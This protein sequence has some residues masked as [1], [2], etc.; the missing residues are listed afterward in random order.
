M[1]Q[2]W[3][4]AEEVLVMSQSW[5]E[6]GEV[7]VMPVLPWGFG[8]PSHSVGLGRFGDATVSLWNWVVLVVPQSRCGIFGDVPVLA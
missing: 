3:H 5:H 8:D 6:A 4:W 1:P 7:S 2:S